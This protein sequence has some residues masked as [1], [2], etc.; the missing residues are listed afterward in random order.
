MRDSL[1]RSIP[2]NGRME[3]D[4]IAPTLTTRCISLS[5]GRYGH[6]EQD[7]AISVR[8][9]AALQTFPDGYIFSDLINLASRHIGNAVPPRFARRFGE[10]F[11]EMV[12][13]KPA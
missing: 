12:K 11:I 8:E 1:E 10:I 9:A 3:W 13:G 7:R 5:N 2:K 6:P 4:E